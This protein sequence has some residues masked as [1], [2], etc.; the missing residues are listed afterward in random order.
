MLAEVKFRAITPEDVAVVMANIRS[1]NVDELE[2]YDGLDLDGIVGWCVNNSQCALTGDID[3]EP[4]CLFGVV[5]A[6][7]PGE[8]APW[9]FGSSLIDRHAV[10]F[11]KASRYVVARLLEE[12][13]HLQNWTDVRNARGLRWLKF[14]GFTI[15]PAE[16]HGPK[17]LLFH[18][19][20]KWSER[21]AS[22]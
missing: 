4:V 19:V 15:H 10:P 8:G 6:E 3:G 22:H 5:D 14:M 13:D 16:P 11:L 21:C 20:E 7:T 9:M 1:E 12:W 17:G 18:R 2:M